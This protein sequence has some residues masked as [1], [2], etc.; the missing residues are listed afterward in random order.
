M[1]HSIK[2]LQSNG[3]RTMRRR[4]ELHESGLKSM[5][6]KQ[7]VT[8]YS[9]CNYVISFTQSISYSTEHQ[10]HHARR[11]VHISILLS[12][13]TFLYSLSLSFATYQDARLF[14]NNLYFLSYSQSSLPLFRSL[15][16]RLLFFSFLFL[17]ILFIRIALIRSLHCDSC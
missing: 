6:D 12:I 1:I 9:H 13:A 10:H 16:L 15:S 2:L 17:L 4:K 3:A 8:H 14:L 11:Y 5:R 7:E